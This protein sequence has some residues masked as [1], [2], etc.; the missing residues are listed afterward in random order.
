VRLDREDA[1]AAG[2]ARV[3]GRVQQLHDLLGT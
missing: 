3:A 1:V 2:A